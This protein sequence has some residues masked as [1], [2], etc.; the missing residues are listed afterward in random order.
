MTETVQKIAIL[1]GGI[2]ALTT[3][4]ELSSQPD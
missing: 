3:A 4:F 1:G 2:S